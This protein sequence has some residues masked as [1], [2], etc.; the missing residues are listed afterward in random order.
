MPSMTIALALHALAAA[1]WVGGMAFAYAVL[2]P[3]AGTVLEG[4]QRQRLWRGVFARFFAVV[5]GAVAVLL[6]SGYFMV[7]AVGGGFAAAAVH[8][9]AMHALGLA[10]AAIFA[11]VYF[12][13]WRRFRG[14]V[15][16]RNP[17]SAAASL[18]RIRRLVALNLVLGL[19]VVAVGA[20]GRYWP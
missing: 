9:H 3:V 7:L 11:W 20:S 12:V 14:A 8:V 1:V 17:E 4:P 18:E 2:R 13:P 10:M 5:W 6:A 16:A 15:D 19:V